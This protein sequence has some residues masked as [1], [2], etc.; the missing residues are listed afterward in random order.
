VYNWDIIGTEILK[1][2]TICLRL[3][4]YNSMSSIHFIVVV[5]MIKY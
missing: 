3:G 4:K 1:L 2:L 5:L